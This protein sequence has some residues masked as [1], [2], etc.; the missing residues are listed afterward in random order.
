ME[1]ILLEK[2][3][4]LG[5]IG[6]KVAVKAGYARNYLIPQNK[7]VRVTNENLQRIEKN[8]AQLELKEKEALDKALDRK[9]LIEKLGVIT[10]P[11]K[12]SEEG[13]LFGSIGTRDI[14]SALAS[15]NIDVSKSE[16]NLPQGPIRL[17]GDYDINFQ[18]HTDVTASIKI[19]I[20]PSA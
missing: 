4:N 20:I 5:S 18:L 14:A 17:A 2:V 11:A 7:A 3:R 16:V 9:A 8:R 13:K 15:Q 10:I 12:A 19:K 6:S 1:I